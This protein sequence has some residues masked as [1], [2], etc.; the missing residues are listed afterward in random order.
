MLAPKIR[1]NGKPSLPPKLIRIDA[2]SNKIANAK[3]CCSGF[4]I[5]YLPTKI[6]FGKFSK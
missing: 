5:L 1:A 2:P 4:D 6:V 3:T